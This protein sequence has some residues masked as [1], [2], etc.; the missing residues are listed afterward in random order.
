MQ[1]STDHIIFVVLVTTF[2]FLVA[3]VFL[4]LY[5]RLYNRS[6]KRQMEQTL[7]LKQQYEAELAKTQMEVQEQTLQTI[8]SDIHDNI[9]QLLSITKLTLS[10]VEPIHQPVKAREKVDNAMELLNTSIRELRQMA[11]VLH[12]TNLLKGGLE[13]AV[14]NELNWLS[15]SDQ[16]DISMK[17]TGDRSPDANPQ[18]DLIAFR[19][20]QELL[21]NTIKHARSTEIVVLFDYQPHGLHITI[22]DNGI[23]FDVAASI[24]KPVGL[25]LHNLFNRAKIIGGTLEIQSSPG[26]GTTAFLKLIHQP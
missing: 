3:A 18:H 2:I 23:G 15:R 10:T 16:Y 12:A 13:N 24:E 22:S 4:L 25:G 5:V 1:I 21:N 6:K 11:S 9:G 17:V 14:N 26:M 7:A 8:A 19:L 20:I